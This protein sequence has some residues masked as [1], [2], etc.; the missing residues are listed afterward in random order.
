MSAKSMSVLERL[1]GCDSTKVFEK[2]LEAIEHGAK[3][4]EIRADPLKYIL[5]GKTKEIVVCT[6]GEGLKVS[7]QIVNEMAKRGDPWA[8]RKLEKDKFLYLSTACGCEEAYCYLESAP[9]RYHRTNAVL[10]DMLKEDPDLENLGGWC[11]EV[12]TVPEEDWA[13]EIRN[14]V[15]LWGSEYVVGWI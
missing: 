9:R 12:F 5:S 6:G 15:D 2:I 10:I 4:E 8:K 13:Y 11:L 7:K 3:P 1:A 14:N